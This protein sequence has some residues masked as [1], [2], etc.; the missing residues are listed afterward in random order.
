MTVNKQFSCLKGLAIIGVVV[1]HAYGNTIG[2]FVNYWHLP[3]FYFVSGYFF[4]QKHIDNP[5][6]YIAGR[7]KRLLI[8]YLLLS[9]IAI[10][11]HNVL[12]KYGIIAGHQYSNIEI[13]EYL[14][15]LF[16]NLSHHEEV[17]GAIWFLISLFFVSMFAITATHILKSHCNSPNYAI[18]VGGGNILPWR[19][20]HYTSSSI[21]ILLVGQYVSNRSVFLR[22]CLLE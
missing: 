11:S 9:I 17:I 21:F 4:K 1:G 3:I 2:V 7:I 22:L 15:E 20:R 16:F 13:A 19:Y 14:K 10:L 12:N 6:V 8:P 5:K 18:W